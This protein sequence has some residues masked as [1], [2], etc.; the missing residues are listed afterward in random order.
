MEMDSP[1]SGDELLFEIMHY[2]FFD[3][4]PIEI[5]KGKHRGSKENFKTSNNNEPK[6]SL[7]DIS[8]RC[9]RPRSR[10]CLMRLQNQEMKY[11]ISDIDDLLKA[12]VS[13]TLQQL[14]Q[15]LI[16]KMGILRYIMQQPDKGWYMQVLTNFFD[17]LK[18]ESR[19]NPEIKVSRPDRHDRAD[20]K[21]QHQAAL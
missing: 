13:V 18:D 12:S 19:K 17:F 3:I 5:A 21:E 2:D 16:A 9:V 15:Q 8:A 10:A 20:E 4:P 1:Y 7:R 11:L 14:F 6:T